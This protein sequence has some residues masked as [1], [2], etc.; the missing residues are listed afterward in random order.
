MKHMNTRKTDIVL[1]LDIPT[2]GYGFNQIGGQGF[3][4]DVLT[5][6][7][8]PLW[9]DLVL[10]RLADRVLNA[11]FADPDCRFSSIMDGSGFNQI[12]GQGF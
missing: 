6:G 9:M 11:I 1:L 3:E 10:I 5:V 12:D 2:R 8:Q 7:L 4:L